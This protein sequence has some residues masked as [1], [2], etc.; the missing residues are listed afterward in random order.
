M[1]LPPALFEAMAQSYAA[2][3]RSPLGRAAPEAVDPER[4]L[5]DVLGSLTPE[6][7]EPA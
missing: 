6:P 5:A 4:A 2:L 3:A 7:Q 1:G